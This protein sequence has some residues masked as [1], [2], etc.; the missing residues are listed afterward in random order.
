MSDDPGDDRADDDRNGDDGERD[1]RDMLRDFLEGNGEIDPAQ[2]A[3][4]AGLPSDPALIAQL[5][6]QLQNAIRA[7]ADGSGPDWS[8]ATN[9]ATQIAQRSSVVSIASERVEL[10]QAL[11]I[12]SLWLAE[13]TSISE[14]GNDP[15]IMS[16]A[17]W[18]AATM[19]VWIELVEPVVG[20][21]GTSMGQLLQEQAPEEFGAA[22]ANAGGIMRSVTQTMY[23]MQLGQVVG[24]LST[25]V[26]SGGDI[27]LPLIGAGEGDQR[28]VMI[29]QNVQAFGAGLDVPADEVRLY[30]AVREIAHAR[31]F[32]HA[33]WLRLQFLTAIA[34]ATRGTSVDTDRLEELMADFDPS[35][36][37]RL[38]D[39]LTNGE[40][41]A[42]RSPEQE[43][44]LARIETTLALIEGWVDVVTEQATARLPHAASI[45]E[46][47]R[48]RRASAGPSEQALAALVGLELR[49][50]RLREAAAMW[51]AVTDAVGADARDALWSH[52]DLAPTAADIDE[53]TLLIARAAGDEPEADSIDRAIEDLLR[54]DTDRPREE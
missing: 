28:A 31:L 30:L 47:V 44:A 53:P 42:K 40:L 34:E 22:L 19:P 4:A 49:P 3:S 50:R 13:A 29:P 41:L 2:L 17:E 45:A 48:R 16:R 32:R 36:P 5:M 51:H 6:S 12:A 21:I 46:A 18:V 9:Q 27:G 11:R 10:E 14:L 33:R 24:G 52:P 23:A 25:E 20:N 15:Q 35:N 7:D 38:R 54:D 26:V 37:E 8:V 39:A 1:I 43:A